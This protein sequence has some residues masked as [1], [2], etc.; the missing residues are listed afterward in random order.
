MK[1]KS[2]PAREPPPAPTLAIVIPALNEAATLPTLFGDL[3]RA[4]DSFPPFEVVVSDGGSTDGTPGCARAFGARVCDAARGRARQMN[5]G[6]GATSAPFLFFLHADS[7]LPA[8]ALH[9]LAKWIET[10]GPENAAH[11]RFAIDAPGLRW[12]LI[13]KGQRLR[14][15]V[16]GLVYGDQGLLLARA[17]FDAAGGF[18][19]VPLMEDVALVGKLRR[20]GGVRAL[21]AAIPTS[22]R[23]YA[24]EG[25]LRGVSRNLALIT[26]YHLGVSSVR[27]APFYPSDPGPARAPTAPAPSRLPCTLQVFV[28]APVPG[29]VKTRLA[30]TLGAEG[31]ARLYAEL[32]PAIVAP[33]SADPRW[34]TEIHV[35]PEPKSETDD[36]DDPDDPAA[37]QARDSDVMRKKFEG[38]GIRGWLPFVGL[39]FHEQQGSDLGARMFRALSAPRGRGH[40][41]LIGSDAP[42]MNPDAV[43]RAFDAL[44]SG[45]C[46]LVFAPAE[47]GGYALVG[48][49]DNADFWARTA[50]LFQDVPW[51]TNRVLGIT[52][53]RAAEAG[54][55]VYLLP[56]VRDID[57]AEDLRAEAPDLA[58]RYLHA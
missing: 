30:A 7:R 50:H 37:V 43:G 31:A 39:S 57:T 4:P 24:A 5:A 6:A 27:L 26:F 25:F 18:P 44:S 16:T 28:K 33:L 58:A 11:F 9:A 40:V 17:R 54:L 14:E 19:E 41:C 2:V 34:R 35:A 3:S 32:A 1:S 36:P 49:R 47:D 22:P 48:I 21:T 45:T 8:A 15:R 55:R 10:P 46:D 23:R 29:Q 13:E 52:L 20:T 12:R 53:K 42:A 38:D 56:T 51:S